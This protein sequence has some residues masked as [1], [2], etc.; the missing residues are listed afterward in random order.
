MLKDENGREV[1]D[2]NGFP[3]AENR[4]FDIRGKKFADLPEELQDRF[5]E[6]NF[7]YDQYLN[8]TESDIAYHIERYNDGKPMTASQR[9][10]TKLGTEYAQIVKSI[11]NM[12]FFKDMG[13]YKVSEF[14]NGTIHRVV[15]E[16]VMA[17]NYLED[18][19]KK[20][21]DLS[22]IHI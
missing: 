5:M 9:G 14:K 22:L 6:Y 15:V 3:V 8:C 4:E 13:G 19:K 20:Q 1:L 18:W 10:I 17:V 12:P 21:E 11:S 16:S 2:E 7:N